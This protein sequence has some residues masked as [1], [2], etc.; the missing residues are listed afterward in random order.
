M[1]LKCLILG[2]SFVR[3]LKNFIG[4]NLSS[5]KYTL[6]LDPKEVM[7]QFAGK[8]G[9]NIKSL[10]ELQLGDVQDF[11][12]ELVILDIGTNDLCLTTCD[13]VKLSSAIVGLVDS[14]ITD[15]NVK[16]VVVL[17]ILHRF[18]PLRPIRPTRRQVNIEQFNSDVDT[19][20]K[21]LDD[22][23]SQKQN[24]KFWWHKGLWGVNQRRM[25]DQDGVHFSKPKGQRKYFCNLWAIVVHYINT[26]RNRM[27]Q[28][29]WH[30]RLHNATSLLLRGQP[31][32]YTTSIIH[33]VYARNTAHRT[34]ATPP[35]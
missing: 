35:G 34:T 5:Y 4:S 12:P 10:K 9:A 7:I 27:V 32:T 23:L 19:C 6:K 1:V 21:I 17:Q 24:C 22:K 2:H 20:N 30:C 11:E 28:S 18:R 13:P 31:I 33:V 25:I 8:P 26:I 29:S 15:F 3:N 16:H 14:L